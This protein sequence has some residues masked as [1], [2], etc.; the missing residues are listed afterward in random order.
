MHLCAAMEH[1]IDALGQLLVPPPVEPEAGPREIP[2][3]R[4]EALRRRRV[5]QRAP[6]ERLPQA[7]LGFPG[8]TGP[9]QTI[10]GRTGMAHQVAGEI[11]PEEPRGAREQHVGAARRVDRGSQRGEKPRPRDGIDP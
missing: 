11:G 3:H 7:L 8:R 5:V 9:D 2:R 10:D 6:P 4:H 1:L